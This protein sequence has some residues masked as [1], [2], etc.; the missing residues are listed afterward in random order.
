MLKC[1]NLIEMASDYL[2]GDLPFAQRLSIRFH[3]FM[4]IHCKRYLSQFR[5]SVNTIHELKEENEVS[6]EKIEAVLNLLQKKKSCD[7]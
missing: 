6:E 7:L 3:L 1:Q 2:D 5:L 4:C